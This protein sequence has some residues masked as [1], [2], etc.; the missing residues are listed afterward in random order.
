MATLY[1]TPPQKLRD[2]AVRR[3]DDLCKELVCLAAF[4]LDGQP[5]A[6]KKVYEA[7]RVLQSLKAAAIA[8]DSKD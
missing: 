3:T 8:P 4:N 1:R 6:Q 2:R 5:N 7:V